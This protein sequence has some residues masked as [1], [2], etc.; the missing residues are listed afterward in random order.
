M[1]Q[2]AR[3]KPNPAGKDTYRGYAPASQLAAEWVDITNAGTLPVVLNGISLYHR[4]FTAGNAR[5]ALVTSLQ[6]SLPAGRTLRVHAGRGGVGVVRQADLIGADYHAFTG[7]DRYVWNNREGDTPLLWHDAQKV[8]IDAAAY[9]P[10]P[11]E[12]AV[13]VRVGDRLV[14]R[15]AQTWVR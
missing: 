7:E 1:L 3:I 4:A 15:S 8:Q 5:W 13:L 2:I 10:N 9:D 12:G 11:P 14:P 6:G